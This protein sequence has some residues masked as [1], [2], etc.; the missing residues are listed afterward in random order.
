M[1]LNG[2]GQQRL[3]HGDG[4]HHLQF[5]ADGHYAIDSYSRMDMPS[6]YNVVNVEQPKKHF[7]FCRVNASDAQKAGWVKPTLVKVKAADEKTDLYGVMYT[8]SWL[9]VSSLQSKD[10]GVSLPIIS[11]VYPGPQDDQIPL[12]PDLSGIKGLD[13]GLALKA[14]GGKGP[15]RVRRR[16]LF[17]HFLRQRRRQ[18]RHF[19]SRHAFRHGRRRHVYVLPR[20]FGCLRQPEGRDAHAASA[21]EI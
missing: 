5:S 9:D 10:H 6:V 19:S 2:R 8:P 12:L 15:E 16:D 11:N 18:K 17:H 14:G 21:D 4:E 13:G 1:N 7:E 3:T 20:S